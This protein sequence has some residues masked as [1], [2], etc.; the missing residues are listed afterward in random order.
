VPIEWQGDAH[1]T[2]KLPDSGVRLISFEARDGLSAELE[3]PN[4]IV[5]LQAIEATLSNAPT[6]F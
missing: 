3:T 1:P 4:G 6:T 2:D 5:E